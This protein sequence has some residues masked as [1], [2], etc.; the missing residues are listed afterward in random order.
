LFGIL[1]LAAARAYAKTERYGFLI[2]LLLL[3]THWL[4]V[5]IYPVRNMALGAIF[6]MVQL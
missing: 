5:A 1:P 2:L 4:D 6:W 3:Y